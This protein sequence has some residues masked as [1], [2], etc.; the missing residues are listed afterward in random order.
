MVNGLGWNPERAGAMSP[1]E[2]EA[3]KMKKTD[4]ER[5]KEKRF[6]EIDKAIVHYVFTI[7]LSALTAI[8]IVTIAT[9]K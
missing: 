7:L 6:Q 8:V 9:T 2:R 1:A 4:Y 5:E 3:I